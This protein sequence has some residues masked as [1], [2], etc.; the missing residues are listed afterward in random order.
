MLGVAITSVVVM[1]FALLWVLDTSTPSPVGTQAAGI[2]V[3]KAADLVSVSKKDL[4][5]SPNAQEGTFSVRAVLSAESG[6]SY[7]DAC[8]NKTVLFVYDAAGQTSASQAVTFSSQKS[9]D[10]I[11]GFIASERSTA[12]QLFGSAA[13]VTSITVRAYVLDNAVDTD[14]TPG[15]LIGT[16]TFTAPPAGGTG[17]GG[18]PTYPAPSTTPGT[19]TG[20][21]T[22]T[23]KPASPSE[24]CQSDR[25]QYDP[26]TGTCLPKTGNTGALSSQKDIFGLANVVIKIMLS[27]AFVIAVIYVIIGG[28]QLI[29][30]SGNEEQA[31]QGRRTVTYALVGIVVI[32]MAYAL[33]SVV[34]N[35]ISTGGT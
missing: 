3:C 21:G 5:V 12:E 33:V 24:L 17:T 27:L 13:K 2:G 18:G 1:G 26:V 15:K 20:T 34:T 31:T 9:G 16:Q 28:Y 8:A 23:G 14:L 22:G 6:S 7:G 19:G 30:S 11:I 25:F 29:T 10:A 35:L 32:I 4:S